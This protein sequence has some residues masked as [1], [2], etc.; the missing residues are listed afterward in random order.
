MD[1]NKIFKKLREKDKNVK[2]KWK[3]KYGK[4][5]RDLHKIIMF[6]SIE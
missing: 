5:G 2:E 4:G 3:S 6:N 1:V